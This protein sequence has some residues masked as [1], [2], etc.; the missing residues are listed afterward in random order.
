M[1][2]EHQ[3]EVER[4]KAHKDYIAAYDTAGVTYG[5]IIMSVEKESSAVLA[6][7]RDMQAAGTL[8]PQTYADLDSHV[9]FFFGNALERA[10]VSYAATEHQ[11]QSEY[12]ARL[13]QINAAD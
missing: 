2:D 12:R 13:E 9:R 5:G 4:E 3:K 6:A 8:S 11:L 7:L 10:R 1:T